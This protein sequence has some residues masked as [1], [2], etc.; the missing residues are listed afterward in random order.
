[1]THDAYDSH[2]QAQ[3]GPERDR[4]SGHVHRPAVDR[5]QYAH[6]PGWGAD[7]DK[8]DRP[9]V[10]MERT[11]PRLDGIHWERPPQQ[12]SDVEVLHSTE[13]AGL[14][15]VYGTTVPPRGISGMLRR[16]GFRYSENDLRRWLIL[17]LADRVDVVEGLAGD[18]A[19]GHVPRVY[20]EMGGRAELR[21]NPAGA[22]RKV[23]TVAALAGVAYWLWQ[24]RRRD[25]S[26]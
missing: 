12:V 6:I 5:T 16:A 22:V 1:M 7:L 19:R 23:V 25:D 4:A 26:H 9:A 20:A 14:T 8:H 11:P 2:G 17:L 13:R 18:V 3:D 15:P 21:H 10:P 24:R